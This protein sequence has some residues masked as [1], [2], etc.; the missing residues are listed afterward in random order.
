MDILI[1]CGFKKGLGDMTTNRTKLQYWLAIIGS[2]VLA[3]VETGVVEA[4]ANTTGGL[5]TMIVA[6][7]WGAVQSHYDKAKQDVIVGEPVTGVM[8]KVAQ[9]REVGK[10]IKDM[11]KKK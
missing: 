4:G 7:V 9:A 1:F 5:I 2:A 10:A 6:A 3:G 8:G 11:T